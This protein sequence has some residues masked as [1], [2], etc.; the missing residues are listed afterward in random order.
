VNQALHIFRKDLRH[1]WPEAAC[2][3][4]A[5]IAFTAA[6]PAQWQAAGLTPSVAAIPISLQTLAAILTGLVPLSWFILIVRLFQDENPVGHRACWLTKPYE[7]PKLLLAKSAFLILFVYVPFTAAQIALLLRA[8]FAPSHYIVGIAVNL[9]CNT[10]I[11]ILPPACIAVVTS[12]FFRAVLTLF[13]T[14]GIVIAIALV[15][16]EAFPSV[17]IPFDDEISPVMV[18][19][20]GWA[21]LLAQYATRNLWVSRALMLSLGVFIA[22]MAINPLEVPMLERIYYLRSPGPN[23]IPVDIALSTDPEHL[24]T[25]TRDDDPKHSSVN[26]PLEISGVPYGFV[27]EPN[28]VQL[29]IEA[30]GGRHFTSH[31][32]S[33]DNHTYSD[34]TR[35][36][37][38]S[39]SVDR[40]FLD[41]VAGQPVSIT[42]SLALT[43][44]E[45]GTPS[46]YTLPARGD[47]VIPG[48]GICSLER[49]PITGDRSLRCRYAMGQPGRTRLTA[50]VSVEPC[51]LD[52]SGPSHSFPESTEVGS[53][54]KDP[55]EFGITSVWDAGIDFT[56]NGT[57]DVTDYSAPKT[58]VCPGSTLTVTPYHLVR[59]SLYDVVMPHVTL[60]T[61]SPL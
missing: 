55:A 20:V 45:A 38:I 29:P 2:S 60:V 37:S 30:H 17:S 48:F 25:I 27:V 9:F 34:A 23:P 3:I 44:M 52:G 32:H 24:P 33:I 58:H 56:Y 39:A 8:G 6:Y 21:V 35:A 40:A 47:L 61:K 42:A 36:G 5:T 54:E 57:S 49:D 43:Q 53:V 15:A 7:W 51:P 28:D 41:Q 16:T 11:L 46:R 14:V 13:F 19:V 50:W 10:I 18:F 26:L 22:F 12:N 1:F 4:L 59:R 31:W